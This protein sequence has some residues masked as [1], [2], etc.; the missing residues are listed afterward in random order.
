MEFVFTDRIRE[1]FTR[2]KIFFRDGMFNP[3]EVCHYEPG[4]V[5]EPY[6]GI[7]AGGSLF[8]IGSFSFSSS[9]FDPAQKVG[10]YCSISWNVQIMA[11]NHPLD[12]VSTS[13]FAYDQH[14]PMYKTSLIDFGI[15]AFNYKLKTMSRP[16]REDLPLVEHD[17]WI[18]QNTLIGRGLS[19][20][21]G[22]VVAAGS[23]V[24]KPVEPYWIVGGNPARKIRRRFADEL[25]ERMLAAEWWRYKFPDFN[26]MP[27]DDPAR[28][29][30]DLEK[31]IEVGD[32]QP[33]EPERKP[34]DEIF[35]EAE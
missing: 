35:A 12:F 32:I 13:Q 18:G 11:D 26:H 8:E 7:L 27:F 25:C 1:A 15:E 30:G 17:V 16:G 23:V 6:C 2:N 9:G 19:L 22:S 31:Q 24:T 34:V 21:T 3:G 10:R 28:F 4:F 33:F 5:P 29:I 20:G 14:S